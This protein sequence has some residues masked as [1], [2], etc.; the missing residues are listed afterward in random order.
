MRQNTA[1]TGFC[2]ARYNRAGIKYFLLQNFRRLGLLVRDYG[3]AC[4]TEAFFVLSRRAGCLC[5]SYFVA[6]PLQIEITTSQDGVGMAS[7]ASEQFLQ[8]SIFGSS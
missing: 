5:L 8:V 2:A 6:K 7:E 1:V 3:F 4:D